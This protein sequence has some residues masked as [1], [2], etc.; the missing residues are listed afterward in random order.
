MKVFFALLMMFMVIVCYG[1]ELTVDQLKLYNRQRLSAEPRQSGIGFLG[2]G[3]ISYSQTQQWTAYKGTTIIQEPEFFRIA[4]FEEDAVA[5]EQ[6]GQ[7]T[8][9]LLFGGL[10]SCVVS[11][12]VAL[13]FQDN[14]I[15]A[16]PCV[17]VSTVSIGAVYA[18]IGMIGRQ[19]APYSMALEVA[20]NY[21]ARLKRQISYK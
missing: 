1:Q 17:V 8:M 5:A 19:K 20:D 7:F 18:G 13:V 3:T 14:Y 12:L 2:Q 4:G 6:H 9:T 21:N 15:I 11:A 16:M 10:A